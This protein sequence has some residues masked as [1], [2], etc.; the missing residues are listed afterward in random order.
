[1]EE[2]EHSLL[3]A[4]S[5]SRWLKCPPSA[6]LCKDIET[7]TSVYAEEGTEA[8]ELAERKLLLLFKKIS[9]E[10]YNSWYTM[11]RARSKFWSEEMEEYVNVYVNTVLE[12]AEGYT[13]IYFELRVDYSD[14]INVPDHK[15]TCD[16]AI[17][18]PD[19]LT[20]MDL[21]YGKG[22]LVQAEENSQLSLYALAA[23]QTLKIEVSKIRLMIV[24]P[25]LENFSSWD[26]DFATLYKWG[27]GYARERAQLAIQGKGDFCPGE[28]QCRFCK[29]RGSCNARAQANI[30]EAKEVFG[31]EHNVGELTIPEQSKALAHQI[32]LEKLAI[33]LEIGP[34]YSQWFNDV[35]AYAYQLAMSGIQIPGFKLVQG[36]TNRKVDNEEGL[37]RV[38]TAQGIP[39]K[40]LYK[41]PTL[42]GLGELEKLVGKKTFETLSKPFV[43]KPMGKPTLVPESDKRAPI[44]VSQMAIDV[45]SQEPQLDGEEE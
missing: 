10:E 24:Q 39:E 12:Q 26:T 3:S 19:R 8:H 36:K 14:I 28:K 42:K 30:E 45:F 37:V 15:G 41:E 5:S 6:I 22:V 32:P 7:N 29:L 35:Q 25:R 31:D 16:C 38:L 13:E 2:K 11:F 33:V 21:K 43:T 44:N 17:V 4:S 23:C 34:L 9:Q 27:I 18:F 20:I 40:E 1:M